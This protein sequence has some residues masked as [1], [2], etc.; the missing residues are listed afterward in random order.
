[1]TIAYLC[2]L[3]AFFLPVLLAGYAKMTSGFKP[4]DNRNPREF[5]AKIEGNAL[6]ARWAEQNTLEA[7]PAF[8]AAVIIAHQLHA[9]QHLVDNL[10]MA[11]IALRLVY[12]W[13]Y[14]TDRASLRSLV[15]MAGLAC[16][17][18]LVVIGF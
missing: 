16:T 2:V 14:V 8:F 15:W 4:R 13:C 11:F 5:L 6:R 18:A 1:M 3:F 17:V 9:P 12:A 7:L 10:A